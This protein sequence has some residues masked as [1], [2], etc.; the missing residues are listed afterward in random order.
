MDR[1]VL[2]E[3]LLASRTPTVSVVVPMYN[4]APNIA[5]FVE[6]VTQVMAGMQHSYELIL[7]DDGSR[8]G[9]WEAIEQVA[10]KVPQV[11]GLQLSRNFG[12]QAALLAGLNA[13][14]GQAIISMDGDLQHPP[15]M[16]PTLLQAWQ[17]GAAVVSTRRTYN[18]NTTWF[19][20]FTSSTYYKVF[21]F[22]SEMEM[23]PGHSDFRLLDRRALD[24]LLSFNHTDIFLRGVV[25]WLDYP[26]VVIDFMAD[27]RL[28]G[29][30]K[31]SFKRMLRFA[32]SGILAFSTKPLQMGIKLG[33]GTSILSFLYLA[34]IVVQYFRGNTVEG[35]ASTLGLVSLLFGVLFI[36]LGVIGTYIGRIYV[37]LQRRPAFIVHHRVGATGESR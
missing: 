16:L 36:M 13:A 28:Y 24:H 37:L 35:W 12:H 19:K 29:Q 22:L 4:E 34:Y 17:N 11:L 26:S 3:P 30:S 14:R 1:T 25:S 32:Q 5:H 31:F 2:A 27:D 9:T 18:Q 33:L 8:D 23:E 15:E 10:R 21:S 6:R 20:K 7:V